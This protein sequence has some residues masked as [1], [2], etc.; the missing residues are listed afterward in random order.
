LSVFRSSKH[1]QAQLVDDS[2]GRTLLT[3]SSLAPE[4]RRQFKQGGNKAAAR[5]VGTL[6][7]QRAKAQGVSRVVFD[8]GGCLYHGRVKELAEGAR[9]AGLQ[10]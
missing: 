10:F 6:F 1:I 9:Q 7:G 8:R 2:Q 5:A 4:I 3:V